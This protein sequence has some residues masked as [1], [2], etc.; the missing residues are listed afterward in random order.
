MVYLRTDA[1]EEGVAHVHISENGNTDMKTRSAL[2]AALA[3]VSLG[4]AGVLSIG[5]IQAADAQAQSAQQQ[6]HIDPETGEIL[7]APPPGQAEPGDDADGASQRTR[8]GQPKAWTNDEG[9]E[10]LTPAPDAAPAMQAVRCDDGTLRM[11]HADSAPSES[12]REALCARSR[13]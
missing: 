13:H 7:D 3:V 11:G 9:D 5:A 8:P 4:L 12:E 6:I 10:M 2:A 1:H